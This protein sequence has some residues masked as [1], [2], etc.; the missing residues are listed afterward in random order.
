WTRAI[1]SLLAEMLGEEL[2]R[3]PVG[4]VGRRL[5]VVPAADPGEGVVDTGIGVKGDVAVAA[6]AGVDL[7]LGLGRAELVLGSDVE[8]QRLGDRRRLAQRL[9]DADAVVADA[10]VGV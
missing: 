5:V 3:P 10:G 7:G 6:E 1:R 8:Q 4:E 2:G 9:L